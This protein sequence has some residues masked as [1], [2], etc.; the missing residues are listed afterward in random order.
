MQAK[1]PQL[2]NAF[3]DGG[4]IAVI[5]KAVFEIERPG[6]VGR[7]GFTP[8]QRRAPVRRAG[9]SRGKYRLI[10]GRRHLADGWV[11]VNQRGNFRECSAGASRCGH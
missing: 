9:C 5:G 7:Y 3:R 6:I 10:D 8:V 4:G 1:E 11:V 2:P